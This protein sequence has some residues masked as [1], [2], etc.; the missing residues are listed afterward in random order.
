M[1][2]IRFSNETKEAYCPLSLL[3]M[4]EIKRRRI[5]FSNLRH[6]NFNLRVRFGTLENE[7]REKRICR[8]CEVGCKE[9]EHHNILKCSHLKFLK[10][11][12]EHLELESDIHI[13]WPTTFNFN[14]FLNKRQSKSFAKF[15]FQ[16]WARI[17]NI[18]SMTKCRKHVF[19]CFCF[20]LFLGTGNKF[21]C[22]HVPPA[23]HRKE[24]SPRKIQ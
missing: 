6:G 8:F 18:L 21:N 9:A 12:F 4:I 16:V 22:A 23:M 1:P 5:A 13:T 19:W 14:F 10:P 11:L 2:S 20:N 24:F 15:A 17:E 7:T 3:R